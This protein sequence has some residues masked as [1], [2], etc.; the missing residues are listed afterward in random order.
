MKADHRHQLKQNDF[1]LRVA[2]AT[3]VLATN[4]DRIIIGTV[5]IIVL[6]IA[7]SAYSWWSGR[8]AAQA[9]ALLAVAMQT[10]DAPIVPAPT[11][12][13]AT[14][15]AGTYPTEKA[16]SEAALAAF[17][18]VVDQYPATDAATAARYH[19][20]ASLAAIGRYAEAEKGFQA[21]IDAAGDSLFGATARMGQAEALIA[22][23][24]FDRGIKV[25]EGLSANRDGMLPLDGVLMQLARG[26]QKAGKSA[27]AKTT[28][29]R[30][31]DEF[32]DS[33]YVPQARTE[34]AK[35]G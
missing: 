19:H 14:Q 18:N 10:Y 30:V 3:E 9:E 27:E 33:L 11:V 26:Y 31:V 4:R 6:V 12:P 29:K 32:P 20:A 1:A 2:K 28:F 8:T 7:I 24:E 21:T 15:Q 22:A 16:R 25:L 35:L 13:G 17:Q 5:A 34:L 23:G